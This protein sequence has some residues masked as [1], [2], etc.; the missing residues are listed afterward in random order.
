VRVC[1]A[2]FAERLL[3]CQRGLGVPRTW[4]PVRRWRASLRPGEVWYEQE[5]N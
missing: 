5:A 4:Y 2:C 3:K 1:I